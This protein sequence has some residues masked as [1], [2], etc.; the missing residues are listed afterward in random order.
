M[1]RLF[2][3]KPPK[4][5]ADPPAPTP[6][7]ELVRNLSSRRDPR[8]LGATSSAVALSL[9]SAYYDAY[10]SSS[11][12]STVRER[13]TGWQTAY[14]AARVAIEIAKESSDMFLPLKAVVGAVS[15]LIKN[16]DVSVSRSR[17][18]HPS[19]FA[20]FPLQQT[21]DNVEGVKEI[22]RRMQSL[23]GVL[24]SPVSE[25]DYAEKGRRVELWRFVPVRIQSSVCLSISQEARGGCRKA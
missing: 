11:D 15:I 24:S 25:D 1:R 10:D 8:A 14:G 5:P 9:G 2:K 7:A 20:Y 19:S 17:I 21:S 18:E 22:E 6:R 16:Y 13:D 12:G 4:P 23:S 3:P